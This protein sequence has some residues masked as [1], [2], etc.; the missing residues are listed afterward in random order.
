M[1][2]EIVSRDA[3][4]GARAGLL[5]TPHGIIET[6]CFMPVGTAA[7]VKGVT[8]EQLEE[9]GAQIILA[10]TYHL[11]L[12]P[13]HEAVR[14]MGGLHKFMSWPRPILTD[15]GGYQVM[16]LRG[17]SR[18][19]EDGVQFRSHLDGS[20]HFLS[21][22]RAVEIQMALGPDIMM[23]L[24]ECVEYPA[25]KESLNRAMKLTVR[26][27]RR[28]KEAWVKNRESGVGSRELRKD[29]ESR[30]GKRNSG[31]GQ[32]PASHSLLPTP[33]LFG[34]VQGGTDMGLRRESVE[35][36]MEI[37]F[38]GYA[39]GGLSVGEPK[40]ETYDVTE[41]TAALLPQDRPRYLMGVGTPEDLLECV[42][43]GIDM[44]DCVMPTRNA[45]N[46]SVFT[47]EGKLVVKNARYARDETPLDPTCEC[48]VCRRYSRG[49][50]RHL[51]MA[52]EILGAT[53]ATLHNLHFYLD[54]MRKFRHAIIS[55]GFEKYFSRVR[56]GR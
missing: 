30:V 23:T 40:S 18:V 55:G 31:D 13:G 19:T 27:A 10:N 43:R 11:Y 36:T 6:P 26:W 22:E 3:T 49:Y 50:I 35:S 46:G 52:H 21:P 28:A 25:S 51:F 4:T 2:F 39:L 37:G 32:G 33:Y 12:R 42:A 56:A 5:H 8:Q 45:R 24:D 17:L 38:P 29:G 41:S 15:S 54:T 20:S 48:A 16:S 53:L 44:F 7:T 1:K 47:S 14:E 9:L 34:I